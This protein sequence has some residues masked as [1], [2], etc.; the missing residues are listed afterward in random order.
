VNGLIRRGD[1][2]NIVG[3]FYI[4]IPQKDTNLVINFTPGKD[5]YYN[6]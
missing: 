5:K 3:K 4:N 1:D 2:Q 6:Q